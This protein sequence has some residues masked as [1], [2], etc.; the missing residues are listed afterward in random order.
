MLRVQYTYETRAETVR[1]VCRSLYNFWR[2]QFNGLTVLWL[3]IALPGCWHVKRSQPTP[4]Y[5]IMVGDST[6]WTGRWLRPTW[7]V[8]VCITQ[9]TVYKKKLTGEGLLSHVP[10]LGNRF[11][12]FFF[13]FWISRAPY[14]FPYT[15]QTL[16]TVI[17]GG[18][19]GIGKIGGW[20][21]NGSWNWIGY[22]I[23]QLREFE[24][25]FDRQGVAD[26]GNRPHQFIVVGEEVVVEPFGVRIRLCHH[27]C[28]F[29]IKNKN[30]SH[31]SKPKTKK[32]KD[33]SDPV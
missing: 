15:L 10:I 21:Q 29:Q 6:V 26:V 28:H 13:F 5:F 2:E 25:D 23:D 12:F 7:N 17:T 3:S 27:R 31:K 30:I 32:K 18:S 33:K 22:H 11:L 14:T 24:F 1:N 8:R 20:Y 19:T 4:I 16:W 9:E